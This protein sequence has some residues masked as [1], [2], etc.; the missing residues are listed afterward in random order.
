[1]KKIILATIILVSVMTSSYA[2]DL[3]DV[4][5][6]A[7]TSDQTFQ[8]AKAT[9]LSDTEAY[10]QARAALLPSVVFQAIGEYKRLKLFS[11]PFGLSPISV[12]DRFPSYEYTLNINQT[13]INFSQ[14]AQLPAC[15][16]EC[17]FA[18]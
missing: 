5:K 13:L 18:K 11:P 4:F 7:L 14:W 9:Y 8:S 3:M 1:M 10:P 17:L 2:A 16:Q 6:Q 15:F 12:S